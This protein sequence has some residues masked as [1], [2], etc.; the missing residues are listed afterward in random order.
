MATFLIPAVKKEIRRQLNKV[1]K[2]A[3]TIPATQTTVKRLFLNRGFV[4]LH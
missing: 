1:A 4:L 2:I 3:L